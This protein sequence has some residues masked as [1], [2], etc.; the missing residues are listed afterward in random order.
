MLQELR[1]KE[2]PAEAEAGVIRVWW[3]SDGCQVGARWVS[4]YVR[5]MSGRYSLTSDGVR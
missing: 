5:W 1:R 4:Y 3:V 2:S